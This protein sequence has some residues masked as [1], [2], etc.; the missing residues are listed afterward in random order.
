MSSFYGGRR[1]ASLEI[2]QSYDNYTAMIADQ[3]NIDYNAYVVT[4][5]NNTLYRR[6]QDGY[7]EIT[8]LAIS[9]GE[10]G[11]GGSENAGPT[12]ISSYD[13]IKSQYGGE[14]QYTEATFLNSEMINAGSGEAAEIKYNSF[15]DS[16]TGTS[17]IGFQIPYPDI[18]FTTKS[19]NITFT[20]VNNTNPFKFAWEV[21]VSGSGGGS[22]SSNT[23]YF[24]DL[25][26][27]PAA[28][29]SIDV[30][31]P[32]DN[33]LYDLTTQ[34]ENNTIV[35]LYDKVDATAN[36]TTTYY[37]GD[38]N[39][40][41]SIDISEDGVFTITDIND[42]I[43]TYIFH[44]IDSVTLIDGK[45]KVIYKDGT[46]YISDITYV[47]SIALDEESQKLI[48]T[49]SNQ[50]TDVIS[51]ELNI[52]LK[53]VVTDDNH[54]LV[55]YSGP[56]YRQTYGS[57]S[58]DGLDGWVDYGKV[59]SDN[60]LYIGKNISP[61]VILGTTGGNVLTQSKIISYLNTTYPTGLLGDNLAGKLVTVGYDSENK[62]FY[63]F[64]Y[65]VNSWY[66]ISDTTSTSSET[67]NLSD[68]NFIG[69]IT[70]DPEILE[71]LP[72]GCTWFIT[73]EIN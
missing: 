38:Y 40:I 35:V 55:Y 9:S 60:G 53:T 42:Q 58:Y 5:D 69:P 16:T 61:S 7:Q 67:S 1:G 59:K 44:D 32:I 2:K 23:I 24:Q 17:Y 4:K 56:E 51:N 34:K 6:I 54:L 12:Y 71:Q 25:R 15:Y 10:S 62:S 28:S 48:A 11:G 19:E 63:A 70:T 68:T 57:V 52:I 72:N 3:D 31:N 45:F 36:T 47:Q 37:F 66:F 33:S 41:Q 30:Y 39:A 18:S 20:K 50:T 64:D 73:Q 27:V 65:D 43:F 14:E 29:I 26:A 21:T 13:L 8:K 22:S 46:E 49:Y